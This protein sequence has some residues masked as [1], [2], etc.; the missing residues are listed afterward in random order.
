VW[1]TP[2]EDFWCCHGTLVQAHTNYANHI[3]F[4]GERG[5]VLS[6]YI[7]HEA[8]WQQDGKNV[9][10]HLTQDHQIQFHHRPESLAYDLLVEAEQPTEFM[11]SLRL[12]WWL[13]GEAEITLN[14]EPLPVT[15]GPSSY[16]EIQ[17]V[18]SQD[19]LHL[20]LPK[21]LVTVPLPDDPGTC[22]F[23]DGPVVLAGL[24]P[25][26][27]TSTARG[28]EAG[29]YTARPNYRINSITLAGDPAHPESLLTPDN[30]REWIF[31][32]EGYRTRGQAQSMRFIPLYEVRDEVFTVYFPVV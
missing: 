7:P 11:L 2:T 1:G 17:R 5:L 15:S 8:T 19:R 12:P 16:V 21:K 25:G 9:T 20:L 27:Y 18:W 31:W 26:E 30:E 6:Q 22:G 23:M 24:N 3:W 28:K 29:S 32:R 10:L 4:E 13:S 14:G